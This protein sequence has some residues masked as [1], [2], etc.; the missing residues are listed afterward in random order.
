MKLFLNASGKAKEESSILKW[1]ALIALV[2]MNILNVNKVRI[3]IMP[4]NSTFQ[5]ADYKR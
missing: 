4:G 5:T 3:W 1:Y 2:E